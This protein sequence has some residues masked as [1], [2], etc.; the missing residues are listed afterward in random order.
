MKY[1]IDDREVTKEIFDQ[2]ASKKLPGDNITL[3]DACDGT[4]S[5]MFLD[6]QLQLSFDKINDIRFDGASHADTIRFMVDHIDYNGFEQA[7][8]VLILYFIDGIIL[9]SPYSGLQKYYKQLL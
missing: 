5:E 4:I 8:N 2:R 6:S 3:I 7:G 1:Y 9:L